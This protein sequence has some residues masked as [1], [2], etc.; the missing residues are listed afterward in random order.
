MYHTN[1]VSWNGPY[2][3]QYVN[4]AIIAKDSVCVLLGVKKERLWND[5]VYHLVLMTE[6]HGVVELEKM[7]R[8]YLEEI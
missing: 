7:A 1:H 4:T 3:R 6:E 5:E 8:A 2:R